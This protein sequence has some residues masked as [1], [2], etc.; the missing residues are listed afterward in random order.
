MNLAKYIDHTLLKPESTR[1]DIR[2]ICEEAKQYNTASVCVFTHKAVVF[3]K[4]DI[5]TI[6]GDSVAAAGINGSTCVVVTLAVGMIALE[7]TAAE[8]G[9]DV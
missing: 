1:E 2:R 3:F 7:F 8:T 9:V 5:G 6:N 4:E